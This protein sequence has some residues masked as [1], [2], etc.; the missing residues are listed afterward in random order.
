MERYCTPTWGN[1]STESGVLESVESLDVAGRFS[2]WQAMAKQE[3]SMWASLVVLGLWAEPM[4]RPESFAESKGSPW[5]C[6]SPVTAVMSVTVWI[7]RTALGR[8]MALK[9]TRL[10]LQRCI[11][12]VVKRIAPGAAL[13]WLNWCW[14][15]KPKETAQKL[16]RACGSFVRAEW[17]PT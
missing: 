17:V 3:L 11:D 7:S 16:P 9:Q 8:G 14:R 10:V 2:I 4:H 13:V 12:K 5:G 15:V 1:W 6:R